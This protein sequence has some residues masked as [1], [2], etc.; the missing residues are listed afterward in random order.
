MF[1]EDSPMRQRLVKSS[2]LHLTF[3]GEVKVTQ[4]STHSRHDLLELL[5]LLVSKVVL[6]LIVALVA[7]V[8]LVG[9]VI[10]VGEVELLPLGAVGDDVG[11]VTALE[12]AP[13]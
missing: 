6:F 3:T 12:A 4:G 8:V 7:R 2:C 9:I 10:L 11:G 5:L 1:L 13:G